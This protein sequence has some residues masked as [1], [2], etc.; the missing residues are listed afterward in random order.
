MIILQKQSN[1]ENEDADSKVGKPEN[2]HEASLERQ[3]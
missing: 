3:E 1:Q 2:W